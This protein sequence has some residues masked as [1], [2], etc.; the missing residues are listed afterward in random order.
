MGER[1]NKNIP[2]IFSLLLY[3]GNI[4]R[5]F[6]HTGSIPITIARLKAPLKPIVR[7]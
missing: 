7:D 2:P 5:Y 4:Y 6:P 1:R 3:G